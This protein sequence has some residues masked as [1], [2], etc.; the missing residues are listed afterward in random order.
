M[1]SGRPSFSGHLLIP[2]SFVVFI[3]GV[4]TVENS[5]SA[6]VSPAPRVCAACGCFPSVRWTSV[7]ALLRRHMLCTGGG[8][9]SPSHACFIH[10]HPQVC[11]DM[12]DSLHTASVGEWASLCIP[13][14]RV[15]HSPWTTDTCRALSPGDHP[16]AM[17]CTEVWTQLW[18]GVD[19]WGQLAGTRPAPS[20][21][22]RRKRRRAVPSIT[23]K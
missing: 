9:L 8:G 13:V 7:D 3:G 14:H 5:A 1:S 17:V 10:T 4:D 21:S 2:E 16:F 22:G 20:Q 12:S 23:A 15:V 11:V 6:H 18:R 19:G